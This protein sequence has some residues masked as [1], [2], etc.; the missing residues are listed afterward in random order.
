MEKQIKL[1]ALSHQY[2][3]MFEFIKA[4]LRE[5]GCEE[6]FINKVSLASEEVLVNIINYAYPESSG[7]IS[8]ECKMNDDS[9]GV[10]IVFKDNGISFNPLEK[11]DPDITKPVEEREI[12]GL[13]ILMVKKLMDHVKYERN[14]NMNILSIEKNIY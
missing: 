3:K 13:G 9:K 4:S 5:F 8:I 2:E 11:V 12:G 7:D 14:N 6:E 10:T 1:P